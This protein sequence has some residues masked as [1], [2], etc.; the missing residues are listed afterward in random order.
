MDPEKRNDT[1][2]VG[3]M[4]AADDTADSN[5]EMTVE[6]NA[7]PAVAEPAQPNRTTENTVEA[8]SVTPAA[9]ETPASRPVA[10]TETGT[11]ETTASQ[12][13]STATANT[14]KVSKLDF[15][16]IFR[17]IWQIIVKP[18]TTLRE[19]LPNYDNGQKSGILAGVVLL[20]SVLLSIVT[21]FFGVV[22]NSY[23]SGSGSH[24]SCKISLDFDLLEYWKFGDFLFQTVCSTAVIML[25]MAGVFYG[26]AKLFKSQKLSF[27]RS[28]TVVSLAMVPLV[29][30][31]FVVALLGEFGFIGD[32]VVN[33][34]A[35]LT[36]AGLAYAA[37]IFY[38]GITHETDLTGNK[39]A[40]FVLLGTVATL[41]AL[42]ILAWLI[43]DKI[44][45]GKTTLMLGL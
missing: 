10:T 9:S 39:K 4:S 5:A 43:G 11:A 32:I 24:A 8:S 34:A 36:V 38:E 22:F 7:A 18:L 41:I 20:I 15:Q 40:Y 42:A 14:P 45:L 6:N 31:G 37:I 33:L 17:T 44:G 19:A 21:G 12:P 30:S 28:L 2:G 23:C 13:T 29:A 25:V 35:C 1:T 3:A 26:I 16:N 27:W